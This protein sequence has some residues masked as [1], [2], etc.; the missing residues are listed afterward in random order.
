MPKGLEVLRPDGPA[1]DHLGSLDLQVVK[2]PGPVESAKL[3]HPGRCRRPRHADNK[4]AVLKGLRRIEGEVRGLQ[5]MVDEDTYYIDVLIQV[6]AQRGRSNLWRCNCPMSTLPIA[7][8]MLC[9]KI[10]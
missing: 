3:A 10:C 2:L 4:D 6:S 7:S 9:S 1:R 8:R 5:R